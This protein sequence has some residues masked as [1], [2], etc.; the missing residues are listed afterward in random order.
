MQLYTSIY[1][2]AVMF[3]AKQGMVLRQWYYLFINI[4]LILYCYLPWAV[5]N[6]MLYLSSQFFSQS[7]VF[8]NISSHILLM[9]YLKNI[10]T[11]GELVPRDMQLIEQIITYFIYSYLHCITGTDNVHT[12]HLACCTLTWLWTEGGQ[13]HL[14]CSEMFLEIYISGYQAHSNV[15]A[16]AATSTMWMVQKLF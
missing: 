7:N 2:D 3:V 16:L 10:I 12:S 4:T 13:Y 1:T 15:K 14:N 9:I 8:L 6:A 5:D 11:A